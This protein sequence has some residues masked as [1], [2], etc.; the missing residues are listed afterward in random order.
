MGAY[1]VTFTIADLIRL[2]AKELERKRKK[3]GTIA[4]SDPGPVLRE[5]EIHDSILR[6]CRNRSWYVIHSRMDMPTTQS[7][8]VPDFVIFCDNGL[9]LA[10]EI[11]T[12]TGKLSTEQLSTAAWLTRLKA[13]YAVIRSFQEFLAFYFKITEEINL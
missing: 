13:N 12:G 7:K 6:E 3:L 8:G 9:V 2:Q 11:K 4:Q 1:Q 10:I 5:C